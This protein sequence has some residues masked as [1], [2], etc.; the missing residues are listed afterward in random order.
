MKTLTERALAAYSERETLQRM[1]AAEALRLARLDAHNR[2]K[3]LLGP[4]QAE[5]WV[6]VR[7]RQLS[8]TLDSLTLYQG[9]GR[10]PGTTSLRHYLILADD[11]NCAKILNLVGLGAAIDRKRKRQCR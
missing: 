1:A 2:W 8:I 4:H 5:Q 3:D 9:Y 7:G 10:L 6:S 11:P